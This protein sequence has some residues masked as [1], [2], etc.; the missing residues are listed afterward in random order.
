M[1]DIGDTSVIETYERRLNSRPNISYTLFV[2]ASLGAKSVANKLFLA[3]LFSNREVAVEFL[4]EV[5]LF[6]SSMV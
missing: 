4:K 6:R 2:N 1:T 5:G 3:L